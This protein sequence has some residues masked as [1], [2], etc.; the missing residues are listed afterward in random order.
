M[1]AASLKLPAN[2]SAGPTPVSSASRCLLVFYPRKEPHESRDFL[3]FLRLGNIIAPFLESWEPLPH[4]GKAECRGN[5]Y[6]TLGLN[7]HLLIDKSGQCGVPKYTVPAGW[8]SESQRC[9]PFRLSSCLC[10]GSPP[11]QG[12]LSTLTQ[13]A[14]C[15]SRAF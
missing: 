13:A 7:E 12:A 15:S 14:V 3:S 9:S 11:T 8:V 2:L 4:S 10:A 1:Q 6:T 5:S